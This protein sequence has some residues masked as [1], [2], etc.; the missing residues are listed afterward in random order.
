MPLVQGLSQGYYQ[1][2]SQDS[3][4]SKTCL[5]G[6]SVS[7]FALVTAGGLQVLP[8]SWLDTSFEP[9]GIFIEQLTTG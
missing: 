8:G 9:H 6:G 2:V 4:H 1:S 7:G 3:S 5:G